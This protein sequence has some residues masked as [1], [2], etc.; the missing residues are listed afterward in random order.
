MPDGEMLDC[1]ALYGFCLSMLK[2]L[3]FFGQS[4]FVAALDSGSRSFRS[5]L[6][7]LYKSNRRST[8]PALIPQFPLIRE[9]CRCFGFQIHENPG[10]E[11][12]D[13]IASYVKKLSK[14]PE[15]EIIV[16]SS[17]KDLMQLLAFNQDNDCN[18]KIYDPMKQKYITDEDVVEKF[19][20]QPHLL[21]DV[22]ALMGDCSDNIP[23]IP[24]IGV[25]TASKLI[26]EF[27]SLEKLI[28]NIDRL[29]NS[30]KYEIL[31]REI[32]K[33]ALYKL[34]VTLRTDIAI[35]FEYSETIPLEIEKFLLKYRFESMIK[36]LDGKW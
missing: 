15:F 21:V 19:G 31:K 14:C 35:E 29:P 25:K 8:P 16:I 34:L 3:A 1:G 23:G 32:E 12:D 36:R 2:I 6:Y 9:S 33:A 28:V 5:E 17:D 27:G 10:F 7:P 20:I 22:M 4:M 24:G 30:K 13:I 26:T 18:I 11:A